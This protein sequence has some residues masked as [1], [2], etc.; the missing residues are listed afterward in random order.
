M[1]AKSIKILLMNPELVF[2]RPTHQIGL[3]IV[4]PLFVHFGMNSHKHQHYYYYYYNL[5]II[6]N[7]SGCIMHAHHMIRVHVL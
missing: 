2:D 6:G 5:Y 1:H 7:H 4:V 3:I